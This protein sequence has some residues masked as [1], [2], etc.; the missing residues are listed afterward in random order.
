MNKKE[1]VDSIIE[2]IEIKLQDKHNVYLSD[3]VEMS[4]YSKR[5]VQKAFKDIMGMNVTTYI[6]RR[7][8]TQAAVILKLTKKKLYHIAMDFNFTTQQ[9]FTRSFLREFNVTPTAYR[10]EPGFDCSR[11][12][13]VRGK[14]WDIHNP[15]KKTINP[16]KLNVDRFQYRDGLLNRHYERG[17]KLRLKKITYILAMENEAIIVTNI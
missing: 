1:I 14:H 3:V 2:R 6:K 10:N 12:F 8:L 11:L 4:G 9:S 5:Y 16:L 13:L 7:K 15:V 17:Y